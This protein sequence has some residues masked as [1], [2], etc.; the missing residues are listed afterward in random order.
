MLFD[1]EI[2]AIE[3]VDRI[4]D[5]ITSDDWLVRQRLAEALGN[6]DSEKSRSALRYLTKDPHPNVAE[7]ARVTIDR[8]G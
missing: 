3:A 4:L 2:G 1:L 6:L 8:L 7:A 5:F